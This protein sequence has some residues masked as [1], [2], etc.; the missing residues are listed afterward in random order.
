MKRNLIIPAIIFLMITVCGVSSAT[1]GF[2]VAQGPLE[3][4]VSFSSPA[5]FANHFNG[6]TVFFYVKDAEQRDFETFSLVYPDTIWLKER[7]KNK[8]PQREKHFRLR[9]NYCGVSGWG[10]NAH[11]FY[12]PGRLLE[13]K[14]F[15]LRGTVEENVE[16]LGSFKF[17]L[18][19]DVLTGNLVKWDFSKN[20]NADMAIFSPTITNRLN[21]LIGRSMKIELPDSVQATGTCKEIVYSID[22]RPGKWQPKIVFTFDTDKGKIS[23][24]NL[25]PPFSW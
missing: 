14:L 5:E 8:P 12:T 25:N 1:D 24:T 6:D 11:R 18:L 23:S 7:P 9:T 2:R 4:Y 22:V 13:N 10:V 15:I 17:I 19:E 21:S 20:E 16:Y 3:P